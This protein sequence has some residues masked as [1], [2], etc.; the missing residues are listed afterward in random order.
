MRPSTYNNIEQHYN[1]FHLPTSLP[2]HPDLTYKLD[3]LSNYRPDELQR[4]KAKRL[5]H[6]IK[7]LT[8]LFLMLPSTNFKLLKE[9]LE[10]LHDVARQQDVN[11]MTAYNLGVMFAPHLLWPRYVSLASDQIIKQVHT[12]TYV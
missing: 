11:K 5:S 7:A 8:Y 10:L 3:A 4:L 12:C 2:L 9:L 6:H 1:M